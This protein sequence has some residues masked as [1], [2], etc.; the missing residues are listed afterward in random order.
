MIKKASLY[1]CVVILCGGSLLCSV[2]MWASEQSTLFLS[3]LFGAFFSALEV[4]KFAFFPIAA[5]LTSEGPWTRMS[6]FFL[7]IILLGF[8]IFATVSFLET[9]ANQST[10]NARTSSDTYQFLVNSLKDYEKQIEL[11]NENASNDVESKIYRGR[12]DNALSRIDGIQDKKN[13]ALQRLISFEALPASG[14]QSIFSKWGEASTVRLYFYT[15]VAVVID[16]CGI[17]CLMLLSPTATKQKKK[18]PVKQQVQRNVT[19]SETVKKTKNT[20]AIEKQILD[21]EFGETFST[22]SVIDGTGLRHP[23]I[24]QAIDALI[25]TDRIIRSGKYWKLMNV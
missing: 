20:D 4:C 22:R 12:A 1:F 6:L 24:K 15:F 18:A 3:V 14:V 8:S 10:T 16:V 19:K 9:S 7:G 13:Q 25:D 23:I 11:G 17:I 21:G 2:A 5:S